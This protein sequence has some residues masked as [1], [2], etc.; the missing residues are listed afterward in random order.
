MSTETKL[1]DLLAKELKRSI[2]KLN[3]LREATDKILDII[4]NTLEKLFE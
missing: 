3:Q 1:N 2:K 4:E